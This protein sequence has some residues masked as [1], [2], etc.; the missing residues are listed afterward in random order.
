VVVKILK[1][2]F[3]NFWWGFEVAG[4]LTWP[5][6]LPIT[7]VLLHLYIMLGYRI[8]NIGKCKLAIAAG[9]LLL[10]VY[11]NKIVAYTFLLLYT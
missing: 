8:L 7:L 11:N 9:W 4:I 10:L 6:Y 1:Y 3:S 5:G 2:E